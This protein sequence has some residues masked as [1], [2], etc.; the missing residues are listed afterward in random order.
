[1]WYNL[2]DMRRETRGELAY[3][4]FESLKDSGTL[5]HAVSTR[6]GGVSPAPFDTLNLSQTVG[7]DQTNVAANIERLHD[8]LS[9]DA[10]ATVSA[11]QAQA[12]RVAIVGAAQRG[13]I[14]RGV[15]ALLTNEPG[16][17]LMLRYADCV[18]ILFFDPAHHA[19]SVAHAGWRGTVGKVATHAA[20][21][22]FDSFGTRPRD[23]VACIAPSIGAC[24]YQIGDDV[25][26]QVRAAFDDADELLRVQ[27]DGGT[28]FDLWQANARQLRDLGVEQIEIA[29]ICT[30]DHTNDFYSWRAEKAKTGRFG[31]MIS[32]RESR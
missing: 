19:I 2:S 24:C 29:G 21:A 31:A 15:D 12:D 6:H 25:I 27:P 17:P 7:D 1:M 28:H 16:V 22:M 4:T 3:Y 26:S 30:A 10:R 9:L 11:R 20:R 8:A 13:S 14:V 18:P 23:L 5:I 32:I